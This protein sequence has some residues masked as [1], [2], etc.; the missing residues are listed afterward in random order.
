MAHALL[1]ELAERDGLTGL[2]N[3]RTLNTHLERVW[4][5]ANRDKRDLVAI[6][7]IDIDHFKRYNDRY[8]H[9]PGDAA[10]KAV[11]DVVERQARRPLDLAARYGGE[12]FAAVWY[13][14]APEEL[15]NMGAQI[16]AAVTALSIAHLD[17]PGGKLS[18]SVGIALM[19][20]SAGQS[21]PELLHA[22]DTALYQAKN[23]GRNRV[24]LFR[25]TGADALLAPKRP[26]G[27]P[28]AG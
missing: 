12:E 20:P 1:N 24:V 25:F 14:P 19:R 6:A 4:R 28:E 16:T 26:P 15:E 11:A 22:A 8:G 2:F 5:Q 17:N 27:A 7:M 21:G 13:N 23:Q 18:V 3:R 9:V 10:L